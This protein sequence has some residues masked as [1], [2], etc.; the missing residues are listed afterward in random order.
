MEQLTNIETY[1][2]ILLGLAGAIA[3]LVKIKDSFSVVKKK[4]E[5]KLDLEILEKIEN[6]KTIDKED[7]ET[8]IKKKVDTLFEH[9]ADD[10]TNFIVGLA[11]FV[12]FGLWTIDLFMVSEKFNGWGILTLFCSLLGVLMLFGRN[13]MTDKKTVF[14]KIGF[15]D[16]DN[17]KYGFILFLFTALLTPIL[18]VKNGLTFWVFLTGLFFIISLFSLIK[19]IRKLD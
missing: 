19:N 10:I 16:K 18:I 5:L 9:K 13:S 6:C 11:V 15:F 3:A 8:K 4:Q 14:Y 7:L 12:G 1:L 17:F 2:K